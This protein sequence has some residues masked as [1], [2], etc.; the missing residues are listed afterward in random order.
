MKKIKDWE[1]KKYDEG[2]ESLKK[3]SAISIEPKEKHSVKLEGGIVVQTD[4][5]NNTITLINKDGKK[6][7]LNDLLPEGYVFEFK[8][9]GWRVDSVGKKIPVPAILNEL[10]LIICLHEIGHAVD[11]SINEYPDN[12]YSGTRRGDK[13]KFLKENNVLATQERNAWAWALK[14]IFEFQKQGFI[15]DKITK[16][17]LME[18]AKISLYSHAKVSSK[19]Q[20]PGRGKFL[21]KEL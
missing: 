14:K 6:T 7:E 11:Y 5:K 1:V 21:N 17:R 3:E 19:Y 15:S 12:N 8:N 2:L 18:I 13:D 20:D 10:H 16:K 4:A 9:S